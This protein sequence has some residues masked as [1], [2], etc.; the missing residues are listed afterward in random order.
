MLFMPSDNKRLEIAAV[1]I[2]AICLVFS[3][4]LLKVMADSLHWLFRLSLVE[5]LLFSPISKIPI[6]S[7]DLHKS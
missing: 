5:F 1:L 4:K 2:L 6:F 7:I 3:S